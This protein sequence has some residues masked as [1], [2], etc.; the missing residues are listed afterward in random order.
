MPKRVG[1][2]AVVMISCL[3]LGCERSETIPKAK[4]GAAPID[5]QLTDQ[6]IGQDL[7]GEALSIVPSRVRNVSGDLRPNWILTGQIKSDYSRD[8][9]RV[10]IRVVAYDK[11]ERTNAVLD[12][13]EFEVLDVPAHGAKAFRQQIQLMVFP[14]QFRFTC[15]IWSAMPKAEN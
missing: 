5:Q 8:L 6:Q 4:D 2:V 13:A 7:N 11:D 15:T 14:N 1:L 10:R 12:T 3:A 9:K